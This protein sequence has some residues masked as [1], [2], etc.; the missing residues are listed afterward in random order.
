[1]GW[2]WLCVLAYVLGSLPF[3][4]WIGR[5]VAGVNLRDVGSGNIGATNAGRVLG[6]KWGLVVLAL[7][8]LKGWLAAI[9]LP[10][11]IASWG[12]APSDAEFVHWQ[13]VAGMMA[14]IGHMYSCWLRFNGGKGVATT[15]G[16]IGG[17][18]PQTLVLLL[19]VFVVS[20]TLWGYVSLSSILAALTL[21]VATTIQTVPSEWFHSRWSIM[22]FGWVIP[23]LVIWRHQSNIRR[24]WRGE[25]SKFRSRKGPPVGKP[26]AEGGSSSAE[27]PSPAEGDKISPQ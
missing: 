7:D 24:L 16:V 12:A 6:A 21:C 11:V 23:A 25:E 4:L 5:A 17:L 9:V 10:R 18:M 26:A 14:I 1:M 15:L 13:F 22:L 19:I 3:G 27:S 20:M 8:G 2:L